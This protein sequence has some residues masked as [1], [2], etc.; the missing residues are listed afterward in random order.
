M[1]ES[2]TL[3]YLAYGLYLLWLLAGTGD[4]HLHRRTHLPVTSGVRESALHGAQLAC[5]GAGVLAWLSFVPNR[6]LG[7]VLVALAAVHVLLAYWDTAS[8]DGVR[9]IAPVEQHVH[10]VLD[11]CPWVFAV[12]VL[13]MADA[14]WQWVWQPRALSVWIAL[15]VPAGVLTVL[16]WLLEFAAAAKCR[17]MKM[18][19]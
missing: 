8:A 14:G 1:V 6:L 12:G 7:T 16:P 18:N 19:L 15:V 3:V 4:F 17:R 2:G 10:S 11:A 9:R 5:V 13:V